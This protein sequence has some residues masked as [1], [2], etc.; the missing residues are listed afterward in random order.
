MWNELGEKMAQLSFGKKRRRVNYELMQDVVVWVIQILLVCA[1]AFGLVWYFGQK[2]STIG[3]SMNPQ[4]Q[5]GDIT[6]I[7]RLTYDARKPRRGEVIAFYPKGNENAHYY[8]KR[9]IGLPG[10]TIEYKEGELWIDGEILEEDYETTEMV[11]LGLLEE[12]IVLKDD[13]YFV[14]GDDRGHSED[15]RA[16]NIGNVKRDEIAGKVWFVVSPMNHFGFV[17]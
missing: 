14:L 3:D 13:E 2:V 9:V 17:K 11:E 1:L 7:N 4:L 8:I 16:A 5:N 6:L 15:S 10:E 12:K